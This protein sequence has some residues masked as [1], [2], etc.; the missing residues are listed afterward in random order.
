MLGA[1]PPLALC[2]FVLSF[3]CLVAFLLLALST[4]GH[5]FGADMTSTAFGSLPRNGR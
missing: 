5:F 2:T 3:V 1:C 4:S